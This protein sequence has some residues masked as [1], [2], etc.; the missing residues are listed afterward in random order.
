VE[1]PRGETRKIR[2]EKTAMRTYIDQSEAG[3]DQRASTR[4]F[5]WVVGSLIGLG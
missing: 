4:A 3:Q 2:H 1:K 5:G